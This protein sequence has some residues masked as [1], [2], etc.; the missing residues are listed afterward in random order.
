MEYRISLVDHCDCEYV[1]EG[2]VGIL[3]SSGNFWGEFETTGAAVKY[4]KAE[5]EGFVYFGD[6][7]VW[8]SSGKSVLA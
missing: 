3:E 1:A 6:T 5:A 8:E 4:A 2:K 7:I